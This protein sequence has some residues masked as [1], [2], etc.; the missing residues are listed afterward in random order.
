[1]AGRP[2]IHDTTYGRYPVDLAPLLRK[3]R[4]IGPYISGSMVWSR[5]NVQWYLSETILTLRYS[6]SERRFEDRITLEHTAT[7]FGGRR[8]WLRCIG[9]GGR[10]RVVY[11]GSRGYRCRKCY[12][13]TYQSQREDAASRKLCK[14]QAVRMRLGGKGNMMLPFPAK[15]KGMAWRTYSRLAMQDVALSQ[16]WASAMAVKFRLQV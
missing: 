5:H 4:S 2:E 15:P 11:L 9:C 10:C 8:P 3:T 12:G 7:A 14:C 16:A 13:L 6:H 1:M